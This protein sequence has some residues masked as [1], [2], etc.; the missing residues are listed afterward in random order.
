M[1]SELHANP[2]LGHKKK[3]SAALKKGR[4]SGPVK[5]GAH[6]SEDGP[7]GYNWR[8]GRYSGGKYSRDG[9]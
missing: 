8:R 2:S 6:E 4:D 7:S 5:G 9:L 3:G 1:K